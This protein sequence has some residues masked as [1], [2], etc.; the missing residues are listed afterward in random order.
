MSIEIDASNNGVYLN[1]DGYKYAF[2][3]ITELKQVI[4]LRD[5]EYQEMIK[6]TTK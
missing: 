4:K 5:I 3:T 6:H 2:I 1:G